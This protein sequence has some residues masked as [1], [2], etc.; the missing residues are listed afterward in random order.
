[1]KKVLVGMMAAVVL[2]APVSGVQAHGASNQGKHLKNNPLYD[3]SVTSK[4]STPKWVDQRSKKEKV[5]NGKIELIWED[6]DRAHDVEISW[7]KSGGSWKTKKT[8][9]DGD[10]TFK[11][12]K[13]GQAYVFKVRGYSNCGK[14]GWTREF[15]A[16]P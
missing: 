1:M 6:S 7:K 5:G 2:L 11:D 8:G 15:T 16:M 9:D 10:W 4:P 12:L 13:N 14:S 3:C